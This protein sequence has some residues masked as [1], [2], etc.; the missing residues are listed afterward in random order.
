MSMIEISDTE[1]RIAERVDP[2]IAG[3]L[4]ISREAGGLSFSNAGEAMEFAKMMAV[5]QI[6][7]RKHLRSNVGACLAITVQAIEWGISPY[8]VANKSYLVNDQIAF[9]SQLIQAVILKRAPIKGRFKVEYIGIADKR[10]CKVSATLRD[11]GET[12]DYTSP[13]FGKITPKNSPLWKADPDQQQFYYAGRAL[14]RRHFPDVLLGVYDVDELPQNPNSGPDRARDVTP[15]KS[16]AGKLDALAAPAHV[17]DETATDDADP[18]TGE[19]ADTAQPS[20]A[21]APAEAPPPPAAPDDADDIIND[22]QEPEHGP[23]FDLGQKAA[24]AGS[25]RKAMP[26]ELRAPG[27]KSDA[28][29]WVRGYDGVTA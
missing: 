17:V 27:R 12:V 23:F 28:A 13:E 22:A 20:T 21:T 25:S 6:G 26:A 18:E 19:I 7:I 1:R 4:S 16:L 14:C 3:A 5:S 8:A 10:V 11:T 9:E 24:R 2:T 29:E 15:S